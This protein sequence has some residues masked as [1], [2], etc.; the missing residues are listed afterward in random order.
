[1][2]VQDTD[3]V[4]QA[5]VGDGAPFAVVSSFAPSIDVETTPVKSFAELAQQCDLR[6]RSDYLFYAIRLD[7]KFDHVRTRAGSLPEDSGRLLD[8]AKAKRNSLISPPVDRSSASARLHSQRC[9]AFQDT[10]FISCPMIGRKA[11]IRWM[12]G[13]GRYASG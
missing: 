12:C 8:T 7:G 6:R 10:T 5:S 3:P 4:S 11:A 1:M 13:S 9:S 2:S